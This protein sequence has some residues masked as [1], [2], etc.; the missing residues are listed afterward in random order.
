MAGSGSGLERVCGSADRLA[1]HGVCP[2]VFLTD[3]EV[4][5]FYQIL[6]VSAL[7][8]VFDPWVRVS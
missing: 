6:R 1:R 7:T 3:G 4:C 5:L 8:G 2:G